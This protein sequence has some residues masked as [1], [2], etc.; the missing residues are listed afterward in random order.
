MKRASFLLGCL[1]LAHASSTLA[2]H[3]FLAEYDGDKQVTISGV[4]TELDWRNPHIH[5]YLDVTKPDGAVEKWKF[6]GFPPNMLLRNGWQKDLTLKPGM[7][8]TVFGWQARDGSNLAHSRHITFEDGT[9]VVSGP[10]A[11]TG[12]GQPAAQPQR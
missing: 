7:K 9:R 4:V 8:I 12:G 6:E 10:P 1:F 11:G 3:S 2:H 5:F